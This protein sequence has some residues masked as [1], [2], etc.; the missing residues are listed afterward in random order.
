[1]KLVAFT[2]RW[3]NIYHYILY[4]IPLMFIIRIYCVLATLFGFLAK[5]IL[6]LQYVQ[7]FNISYIASHHFNNYI[8]I[9]LHHII[10]INY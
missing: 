1:M 8:T 7:V 4:N 3:L 2:L 10:K 9:N 6:N 5:F